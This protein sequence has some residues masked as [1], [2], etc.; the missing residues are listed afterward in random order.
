MKCG[1]R[2][3]QELEYFGYEEVISNHSLLDLD[4]R[5]RRPHHQGY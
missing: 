4:Q 3:V 5:Y 2:L 1:H